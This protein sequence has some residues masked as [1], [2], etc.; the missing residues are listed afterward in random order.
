MLVAEGIAAYGT[1]EK[2]YVHAGSITGK[3]ESGCADGPLF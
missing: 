1:H 2:F 3:L